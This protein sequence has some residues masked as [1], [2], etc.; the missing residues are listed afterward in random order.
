MKAL[1]KSK[2][3]ARVLDYIANNIPEMEKHLVGTCNFA[4][5]VKRSQAIDYS[6]EQVALAA[7]CH[8]LARLYSGEDL[9]KTL[10]S[11]GID[12]DSFGFKHS[13]LL[14][15]YVSEIL[16]LEEIGITDESI[17]SAIRKHTTGEKE[18]SVLDK[19]IYVADKLEPR[20]DF[21]GIDELRDLAGKDIIMAFP[22]VIAAVICMVVAHKWPLYYNSVAAYNQ[23]ILEL[24]RPDKLHQ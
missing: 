17:L 14:H 21:Q 12:P 19:L 20:R 1:I 22:S 15:G 3:V 11:R 10:H 5:E 7:L 23:A 4:L 8:D 6:E 2:Q 24:E 18:M 13:I 9:I 16:A